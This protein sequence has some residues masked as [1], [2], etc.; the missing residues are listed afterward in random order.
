[1]RARARAH[2]REKERAQ[3]QQQ[4]SLSTFIYS[5]S[6]LLMRPGVLSRR[7]TA[8]R[9][10]GHGRHPYPPPLSPSPLRYSWC[11]FS[12]PPPCPGH[13]RT[14]VTALERPRA[15]RGRAHPSSTLPPPAS[16]R[17]PR[18][19]ASSREPRRQLGKS[20]TVTSLHAICRYLDRI[21]RRC[22]LM[23]APR[24]SE[25]HQSARIVDPSSREGGLAIPVAKYEYSDTRKLIF[26]S[27]RA[28]HGSAT[29]DAKFAS[30]V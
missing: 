5:S 23:N 30:P 26:R 11:C 6:E 25:R 28:N 22:I 24:P 7:G 15:R 9:V 4:S 27:R 21:S 13:G 19:E 1:M 29:N 3:R 17:A 14:S 8:R 10:A 20:A 12:I 2:A 16:P 18:G